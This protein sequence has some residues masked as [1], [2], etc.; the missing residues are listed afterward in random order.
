M[1]ITIRVGMP[2]DSFT[3]SPVI[4]LLNVKPIIMFIKIQDTSRGNIIG[5]IYILK[6]IT[7]IIIITAITL[8]IRPVIRSFS[9]FRCAKSVICLIIG[10]INFVS[11]KSASSQKQLQHI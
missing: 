9:V 7:G 1:L 5:V 2:R 4:D 8:D 3:K 6:R 10:R 11:I